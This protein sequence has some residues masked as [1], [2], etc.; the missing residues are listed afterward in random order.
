VVKN[1]ALAAAYAGAHLF[2]VEVFEPATSN[3]LMAALLVHDLRVPAPA[4][5]YTWQDEAHGAAHGG[6]WRGPYAPRS[7]LGLAA[8]IGFGGARG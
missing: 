2:D 1:R 8:M 6:L 4:A 7:A 5:E 3:T